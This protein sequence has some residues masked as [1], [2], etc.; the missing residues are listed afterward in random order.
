MTWTIKH[1]KINNRVA[2]QI[3]TKIGP[4]AF[5]PISDNETSFVY[6]INNSNV[7]KKGTL[8]NL[9][10]NHNSIYKINEFKEISS[11]KL[12]IFNLFFAL[13][14]MGLNSSKSLTKVSDFISILFNNVINLVFGNLLSIS[15]R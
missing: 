6:S 13:I 3:F 8:T 14:N 11:F 15:L 1:N 9:V 10:N 12:S 4:L 5:L 2:R 7:L